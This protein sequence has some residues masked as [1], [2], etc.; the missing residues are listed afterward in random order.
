MGKPS[1]SLLELTL[2]QAA[3]LV[4]SREVS[5][6]EL[7]DA[8]L[9][10]IGA[11]N[12]RLR[13]YITVF[14]EARKVAKAAETMIAAGHDLGPLHGIP[15]ALK[16]NLAVK[17][18]RTTAGS[19]VL[20]DWMPG[21]DATV[22]ERLRRAGAIFVGK[23]NMHEFAWGGTT[24]NPHYGACRNPWDTERFPAGSSG[25]SG[26]A[27]AARTCYGAIGTDTGGS[28]RLPSAINGVVG[29]RPTYGR[30]SNHG[31]IPL[32]WSMDTAGPM[33]RTVEDC[34]I[35]FN[36]IAGHDAKD[37]STSRAPVSD[38]TA[39]LQLG[40]K[41]LRIGVVPGYFFHHLQPPVHDA[42]KGALKT[43]EG[44]GADVVD[45]NIENIHGNISAQLTIE[46]AEPSTYHQRWLR[47]QPQNY[48]E[49][50]RSLLEIGEMLL[51][52][53]YLQAQR[54]RTL[55]R[56]EFMEAFKKV[57]VFICP[58]LPVTATKVGAMKVIIE[59]GVEEDMLSA[60]MQFTGV[61]SLTG[62]P[63]L[64]VPCGFDGDGLPVGMQII[65]KPFDEAFL[66]RIGS[67]FQSAT[68]F[69][70]KAPKI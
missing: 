29:I 50:V 1:G 22:T 16:D 30:V 54:Y 25:G 66:F 64:N 26:V 48:G 60:I 27:V 61:P 7:V 38:Y 46:S 36:T 32:A 33:T 65:G 53:H 59:N 68:D 41:G 11:V 44:L 15:I 37:S 40:V 13:A 62:L 17:G 18:T 69:H 39:G 58:T 2:A 63:S 51:A 45:V 42:V 5:P 12:D 10:R 57:D 35:M 28:I 19:K 56:Q 6:V 34:A 8:C 55:L 21:H 70:K 3:A 14:E 52:T 20:A 23:L 49:D 24:D 4:K 47:E 9:A 43:L 67:A 31:I